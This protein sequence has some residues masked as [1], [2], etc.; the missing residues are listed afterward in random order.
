MRQFWFLCG[1]LS[2]TLFAGVRRTDSQTNAGTA[3]SA[4]SYRLSVSVD[5]VILTFHA[6]DAH[7]LPV[8]DLKAGDL[9]LFDN[10]KPQHRIL[11]FQYLESLPIRAGILVDTSESMEQDLNGNRA[12]ATRYTQRLLRQKSDQGFVI[13]FGALSEITQPWTSDANSLAA[14]IRRSTGYGRGSLHGTAL[15]DAIYGACLNQFAHI[16]YGTSGNF[17]LLFPTAKIM[18]AILHSGRPWICA[19]I[20]VQPSMRFGWTHKPAFSLQVRR[21]WAI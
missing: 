14:G 1:L 15:F 21:Y 5:E 19:S 3:E 12:I 8:K 7:G 10:G 17:I 9:S 2:L 18:P 16:D 20:P 6:N 4:A 11:A 13:K